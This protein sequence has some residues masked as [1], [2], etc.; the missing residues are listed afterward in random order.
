VGAWGGDNWRGEA[1]GGGGKG[2]KLRERGDGWSKEGRGGGRE[3]GGWGGGE[4]GGWVDGD[5]KGE[6]YEPVRSITP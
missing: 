4:G 2:G 6:R 5:G 3:G 1:R